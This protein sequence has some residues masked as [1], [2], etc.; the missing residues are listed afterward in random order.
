MTIPLRILFTNKGLYE[1]PDMAD[2][3][4]ALRKQGHEIL[5]DPSLDAY[6]FIVGP[7][8]WFLR[9][10]V[11]GLF[12]LAVKNA[13]RIAN[14]DTERVAQVTATKAAKTKPRRPRKVAT[15][16]PAVKET[17]TGA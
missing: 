16:N 7:N 10:D 8:C 11:A 14:A 12:T 4:A 1:H 15:G 13:R 5:F 6:D 2:Q 3:L 9:A 17:I